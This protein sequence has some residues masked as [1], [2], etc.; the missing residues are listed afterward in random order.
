MSSKIVAMDKKLDKVDKDVNDVG[1]PYGWTYLGQGTYGTSD[2]FYY[3]AG[4]SLTECVGMCNLKRHADGASWNGIVWDF[5]HH[6]CWCEKNDQGHDAGY[7]NYVHF[8]AI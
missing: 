7:P 4:L 1:Y 2:D 6:Q 5:T 8:K 3:K